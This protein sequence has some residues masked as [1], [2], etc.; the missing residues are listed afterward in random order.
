MRTVNRLGR[1]LQE[2][3]DGF[4]LAARE[5]NATT[6]SRDVKVRP[7]WANHGEAPFELIRP[8]GCHRLFQTESRG[9][10]RVE[11]QV[12]VDQERQRRRQA[13]KLTSPVREEGVSVRRQ[14]PCGLSESAI[15]YA[16]MA[17]HPLQCGI[18]LSEC[19]PEVP[20][21]ASKP[22]FHVEHI[23]VQQ[24]PSKLWLTIQEQLGILADQLDLNGQSTRRLV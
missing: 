12:T 4:R 22:W 6:V 3:D 18:T 24:S 19:A 1:Q 11:A 10:P 23:P 13:Q 9:T 5:P 15:P 2:G 21:N 20:M 7:R 8:R 16:L 17:S 14:R